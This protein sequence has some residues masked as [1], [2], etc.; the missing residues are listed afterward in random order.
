MG[1]FISFDEGGWDCGR[2]KRVLTLSTL[3]MQIDKL[4]L[5][6]LKISKAISGIIKCG[7]NRY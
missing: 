6:N 1:R 4:C 3:V 2:E 5:F 7:Q